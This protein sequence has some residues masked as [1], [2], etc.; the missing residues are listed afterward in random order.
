MKASIII[1][2]Q[3]NEKHILN[4]LE[5][6]SLQDF[7]NFEVLMVDFCSTDQTLTRAKSFPIKA[8]RLESGEKNLPRAINL[9]TKICQGEII[10]CLGGN[11]VPKNTNFISS[12]LETFKNQKTALAFGPRIKKDEAPLVRLLNLKI[13]GKEIK[14]IFLDACAF[15]KKFWESNQF[16][17]KEPDPA[18]GGV[19]GRVRWQ[20]CSSAASIGLHP[21]GKPQ[22]I[23]AIPNNEISVWGWSLG[24][25]E[26]GHK[27]IFNPQ[28]ATVVQEKTGLIKHLKEKARIN[29]LYNYFKAGVKR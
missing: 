9:A 13:W 1:V 19:S 10:F 29:K 25:I 26:F 28:M 22:G 5:S 20:S 27:I 2:S 16:S 15:R 3:N 14:N 17:E 21:R 11:V 23:Q 8:F 7:K 24:Q 18:F 12:G 4:L 6:L